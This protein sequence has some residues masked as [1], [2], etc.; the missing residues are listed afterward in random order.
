MLIDL[1]KSEQEVL[2]GIRNSEQ[3]SNKDFSG[4]YFRLSGELGMVVGAAKIYILD[5]YE[6]VK[7]YSDLSLI[8]RCANHEGT[9]YFGKKMERRSKKEGSSSRVISE[10]MRELD[11]ERI[12]IKEF[13]KAVYD[14]S[15]GDFSVVFNGVS[16]NWIDSMSIIELASYIEERIKGEI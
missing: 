4:N 5:N 16:Y 2:N 7:D 8:L 13:D 12:E 6:K 10:M 9:K 15:D 3:Y 14:W 11:K 1:S